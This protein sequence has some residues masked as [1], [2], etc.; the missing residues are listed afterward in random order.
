[1]FK[2]IVTSTLLVGAVMSIIPAMASAKDFHR[3]RARERF[4]YRERIRHERLRG[5]YDRF[6]CW[7]RY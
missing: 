6:G 1:M 3:E 7:H 2:R 4:E 5:W